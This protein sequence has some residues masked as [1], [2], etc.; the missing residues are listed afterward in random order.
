[1]NDGLVVLVGEESGGKGAV[2]GVGKEL[3][4]NVPTRKAAVRVERQ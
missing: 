4:V 2:E 3:P 1:M